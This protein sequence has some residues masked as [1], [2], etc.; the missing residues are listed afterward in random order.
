MAH[1]MLKPTTM[2]A[3]PLLFLSVL[4]IATFPARADIAYCDATAT[5]ALGNVQPWTC[6]AGWL[7]GSGSYIRASGNVL[8][9]SLM[10]YIW[11]MVTPSPGLTVQCTG[12]V[13]TSSSDELMITGGS[14]TGE[15]MGYAM[16]DYAAWHNGRGSAGASEVFLSNFV[17]PTRGGEIIT[18]PF[19]FGV[20]FF[21]T[22]SDDIQFSLSATYPYYS[23]FEDVTSVA[24]TLNVFDNNGNPVPDALISSVP[25]VSSLGLLAT[26]A[27]G[28]GMLRRWNRYP[29]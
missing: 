9:V 5:D 3:F 2:K 1:G 14:G 8:N 16:W 4:V 12:E 13:S 19:I 26:V 24:A 15:L 22:I 25:E 21:L 17:Y 29:R 7:R 11:P 23:E 10:N 20:P 6:S 18:I 28:L 27:A